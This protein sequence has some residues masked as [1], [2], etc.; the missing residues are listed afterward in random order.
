MGLDMYASAVPAGT[1][2]GEIITEMVDT[3]FKKELHY[4]RKH[5]ALH[6][7]MEKLYREKGG[8][9]EFNCVGLNLTYDDLDRLEKDI[10]GVSLPKTEGFFFGNDTSG[11]DHVDDDIEFVLKAKTHLAKGHL[12]FYSA[13]Y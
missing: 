4:W 2:T 11:G 1:Y 5:N 7:W 12:V 9:D 10:L 13:W 3:D 6:G 8:T